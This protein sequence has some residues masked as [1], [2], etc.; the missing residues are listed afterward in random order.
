VHWTSPGQWF[1]SQ[2][3]RPVQGKANSRG[4]SLKWRHA[5][6]RPGGLPKASGRF[7][8]RAGA[9][10]VR[11]WLGMSV[12]DGM[13]VVSWLLIAVFVGLPMAIVAPST[14]ATPGFGVLWFVGWI[15]IGA[16][17]FTMIRWISRDD[18]IRLRRLIIE[19]LE[20]KESSD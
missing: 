12:L 15:S 3:S 13:F 5:L 14:R 18:D 17:L 19:E 16:L 7:E 2:R 9:T 6:T 11:M 8:S 20:A 1:A 4:F 10:I